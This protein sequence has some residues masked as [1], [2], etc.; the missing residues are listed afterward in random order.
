MPPLA[1]FDLDGTLVDTPRGIVECF[2]A[3]FA[4]MSIQSPA[5]VAI[6]TTIGL[7]L[8]EAFGQLLGT[9]VDD[10]LVVL[11][12]ERYQVLFRDLV[13]P[14]AP[15]LVFP[16]VVTGLARLRQSGF[17]LA[18]ATSK[19]YSNADA[20]LR[21]A[22]LRDEFSLVVGSDQVARPKPYPDMGFFIMS[23][24]GATAADTLMVGDATHDI[25]LA[26]GAGIRSIAVSYGAHER[27]EL[28]AATPT[29][30]VDS[31]DEVV[32]CIE[33]TLTDRSG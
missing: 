22:N 14:M 29:W 21:A 8:R 25:R 31:F 11:G 10:G 24:V 19:F 12:V 6:R 4:S 1:I 3:T 2:T 33:A 27:S 17:L 7:P 26:Q 30:L 5:P 28:E 18:V 23:E 15:E 13:L 32:S 16:G 20:L 9:A